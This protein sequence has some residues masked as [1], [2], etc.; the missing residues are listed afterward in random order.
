MRRPYARRRSWATCSPSTSTPK[1]C[2]SFT[3]RRWS[4]GSIRP[5][6]KCWAAAS[7]S[8]AAEP[9]TW[10]HLRLD[11]RTVMV[12]HERGVVR[13][14][15][16]RAPEGGA[17]RLSDT[18]AAIRFR[19]VGPGTTALRLATVADH[20]YLDP[21]AQAAFI[22]AEDGTAVDVVVQEAVVVVRD[23]AR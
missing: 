19:A 18:L 2:G 20:P 3:A 13:L 12:D 22:A 1:T 21:E 10:Q 8:I 14:A 7:A 15:G 6:C 17:A 5:S 11:C 16:I 4:C 9:A 23:D